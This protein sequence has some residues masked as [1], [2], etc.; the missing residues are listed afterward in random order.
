M[1]HN[2]ENVHLAYFLQDMVFTVSVSTRLT[3]T[4][5]LESNYMQG[6]EG[7]A[8][9]K[10]AEADSQP[11]AL[12]QPEANSERWKFLT[13]TVRKVFSGRKK[14]KNDASKYEASK[15]SEQSVKKEAKEASKETKTMASKTVKASK[16]PPK[17]ESPK[18]STKNESVK[19]ARKKSSVKKDSKKF[20]KRNSK[21]S[22]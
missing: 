18:V 15:D 6:I 16:Q 11:E 10:A 19:G 13:T 21:K 22:A 3:L 17:K 4:K 1:P 20:E 12:I 8:P 2:C 14:E 5:I 9:V 7:Q